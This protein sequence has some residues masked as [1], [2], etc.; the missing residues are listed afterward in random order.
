MQAV[1]LIFTK[2]IHNRL[3]VLYKTMKYFAVTILG[4]SAAIPTSKRNLS[5]QLLAYGEQLILI[6]CGEGTQMMLRKLKI[7][8]NKIGHI[9]ISH[10][11]GDHFFGLI[12]LISTWHL[13][14]RKSPLNVY[15]PEELQ[16]IIEIQLKAS[17][18]QL[19]YPLNFFTTQ[20]VSP[21][22]LADTGKLTITSFPLVHRIPTTG[23]LISEK[24]LPRNIRRSEADNYGVP[25]TFME[26]LRQGEDFVDDEGN[27]ITN[28]LLTIPPPQKRSYAYCSDTAFHKPIATWVKG[29]TMLYHEATFLNDKEEVAMQKMHSTAA[30]AAQIASLAGAGTLLLGHFS[31]RYEYPEVFKTEAEKIFEKVVIVEDGITYEINYPSPE[32]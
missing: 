12:G 22:M 30:Q 18:T 32:N 1:F 9:L 29:C 13:L 11:H 26:R 17:M 14:G 8:T 10:L 19:S 23:F 27:I 16:E 25:F 3:R 15:G 21:A 24:P 31:A 7:K 4:S 6:D 5:A 2:I 28:H 20:S